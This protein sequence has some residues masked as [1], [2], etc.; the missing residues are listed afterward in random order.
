MSAEASA[1]GK[2]AGAALAGGPFGLLMAG[3]A[4]IGMMG[5]K[6]KEEALEKQRKKLLEREERAIEEA[7]RGTRSVAGILEREIQSTRA[8][9]AARDPFME[10]AASAGAVQQIGAETR[11]AEL[12]AGGIGT[13]GRVRAQQEQVQQLRG[14][15]MMQNLSMRLQR[16]EKLGETIRGLTGKLADVTQAGVQAQADIRARFGDQISQLEMGQA[17]A[18]DPLSTLVGG[19][20]QGLLSTEAGTEFLF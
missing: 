3:G 19:T 13:G 16:E 11:R 15:A 7:R 17:Q 12:A 2:L 18:P 5:A 1:G 8:A 9:S 4:I 20:L 6:K 14:Q 10:A